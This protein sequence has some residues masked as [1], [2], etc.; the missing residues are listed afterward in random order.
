MKVYQKEIILL[1]YPFSNFQ[2][3][4]VRPALVVSNNE[5]NQKSDDCIVVPLTSVIKDEPYS[6]NIE[7]KDLSSGKPIKLSRVRIDKIFSVEKN[8]IKMKIGIL[9]EKIFKKIKKNLG[10]LF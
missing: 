2:G 8:L 3:N 5:L 6:I 9:D 4:K 1:S 7:Q 10:R